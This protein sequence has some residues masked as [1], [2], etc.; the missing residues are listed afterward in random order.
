MT[1]YMKPLPRPTMESEPFWRGT[2]NHELRIQRCRVCGKHIFYPRSL[3]PECSTTDLEWVQVSGK[4]TVYSYTIIRRAA[5][6]SFAADVP[7]V[8]AIV[9]LEEGP[10]MATNLVGC[11][12]E[13]ARIGLP[14]EATFEDVAPEVTLVKFRPSSMEG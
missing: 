4:G 7:Y 2:R 9:E 3:C 11:P 10:R 13:R 12:P 8:F 5:F 14:V 6:P 1:T